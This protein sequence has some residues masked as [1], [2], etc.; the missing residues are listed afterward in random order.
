MDVLTC[1]AGVLSLWFGHVLRTENKIPALPGDLAQR[2]I[3]ELDAVTKP[4]WSRMAIFLNEK[5]GVEGASHRILEM[6]ASICID[7]GMLQSC[8]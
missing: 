2:L 1:V 3:A 5:R 6:L 7:A 8:L 4:I